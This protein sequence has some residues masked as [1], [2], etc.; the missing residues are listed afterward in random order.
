MNEKY[1]EVVAE[2][3][4]NLLRENKIKPRRLVLELYKREGL[5]INHRTISNYLNGKTCPSAKVLCSLANYFGVPVVEFFCN[6]D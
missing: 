4:R 6:K 3:L 2:K 5:M 1:K